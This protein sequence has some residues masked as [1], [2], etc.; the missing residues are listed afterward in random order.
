MTSRTLT[1]ALKNLM[2]ALNARDN[3]AFCLVAANCAQVTME[4]IT[5]EASRR[6]IGDRNH[7]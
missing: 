6:E 7:Y 4:D 1:E 3:E 2:R 5:N